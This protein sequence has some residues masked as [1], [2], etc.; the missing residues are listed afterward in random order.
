M[1]KLLALAVVSAL[2]V[3]LVA[4]ATADEAKV[5]GAATRTVTIGDN[6][7]KPKRM[8]VR[9]GTV[10]RFVWGA[11]NEGTDFEHNATGVRGNKFESQT[12]TRPERPFRKRITRTTT[13]VCTVH[14]TTMRMKV[15]VKKRRR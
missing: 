1:R 8:T 3:P 6:F 7:F 13:I 9:K 4:T 11:G 12:T 15:V 10:L 5:R 14:A 2:S